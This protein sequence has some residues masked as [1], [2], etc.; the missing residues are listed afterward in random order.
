MAKHTPI[1]RRSKEKWIMDEFKIFR[2]EFDY[3]RHHFFRGW[4]RK[5]RWRIGW[6]EDCPLIR[7]IPTD[8][9]GVILEQRETIPGRSVILGKAMATTVNK[10]R[11]ILF[12]YESLSPCDVGIPFMRALSVHEICHAVLGINEPM[13]G[14]RWQTRMI[15]VA[16]HA[17]KLRQPLLAWFI[18]ADIR[19]EILTGKDLEELEEEILWR[20]MDEDV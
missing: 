5:Y 10:A 14:E 7:I 19:R 9:E 16:Q 1:L 20:G 4:D 6:W 8:K 17:R 15:K 12:V 3:V 18:E 11:V 13:H 2:K